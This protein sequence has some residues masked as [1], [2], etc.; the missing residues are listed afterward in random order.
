[1]LPALAAVGAAA[2]AASSCIPVTQPG[3]AGWF[4]I[5]GS[6]N[7]SIEFEGD[8][9]TFT[10][11]EGAPDMKLAKLGAA[12]LADLVELAREDGI[13]LEGETGNA[14]LAFRAWVNTSTNWIPKYEYTA[15]VLDQND[16]DNLFLTWG[17]NPS[18]YMSIDAFLAQDW[19]GLVY[20][21]EV[22]Y[23]DTSSGKGVQTTVNSLTIGDTVFDFGSEADEAPGLPGKGNENGLGNGN[24]N[25]NPPAHG[26][27]KDKNKA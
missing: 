7:Y 3:E 17:S 14:H 13:S 4:D 11:T 20:Q 10:T 27:D 23:T 26:Q 19:E 21:V 18:D 8:G 16:P 1:M 25:G 6:Q 15:I 9:V 2:L 22:G 5:S 12:S 24:G